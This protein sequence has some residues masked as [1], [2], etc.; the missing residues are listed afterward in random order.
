MSRPT[1]QNSSSSSSGGGGLFSSLKSMVNDLTS[2]SPQPSQQQSSSQVKRP[3]G[4]SSSSSASNNL[5]PSLSVLQNNL[6]QEIQRVRSVLQGSNA[7]LSQLEQGERALDDLI[8][9]LSGQLAELCELRRENSQKLIHRLKQNVSTTSANQTA[10]TNQYVPPSIS[11]QQSPQTTSKVSNSQTQP[12]TSKAP[13][14]TVNKSA[15]TTPQSPQ[16]GGFGTLAT[17]GQKA[18]TTSSTKAP[19]QSNPSTNNT[20][21]GGQVDSIDS[22]LVWQEN[23]V[24]VQSESMSTPPATSS[25]IPTAQ[26]LDPFETTVTTTTMSQ[27]SVQAPS[28]PFADSGIYNAPPGLDSLL[29]PPSVSDILG[30][31][32]IQDD[33]NK[34]QQTGNDFNLDQILGTKKQEEPVGEMLDFSNEGQKIFQSNQILSMFDKQESQDHVVGATIDVEVQDDTGK[35][36]PSDDFDF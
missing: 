9:V 17:R 13:Q 12:P 20:S 19:S 15:T 4:S 34:Q 21:R 32:A 24:P 35:S 2:S 25:N 22:I 1:A 3:T 28:T 7:S 6:P 11:Q 31:D 14:S 36:N 27:P 5:F 8:C 18:L 23:E 16:Q 33:S 26:L 29:Q 30:G 10:T